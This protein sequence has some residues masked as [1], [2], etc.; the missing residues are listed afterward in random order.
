MKPAAPTGNTFLATSDAAA[1]ATPARTAQGSP[2]ATV[3]QSKALE[4]LVELNVALSEMT[5]EQAALEQDLA[6]VLTPEEAKQIPANIAATGGI[7]QRI[8]NVILRVKQ[9]TAHLKE[10]RARAEDLRSA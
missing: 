3:K 7:A 9:L 8:G 4:Q 2:F 6:D 10:L 1:A 5:A